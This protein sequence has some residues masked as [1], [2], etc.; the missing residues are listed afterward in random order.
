MKKIYLKQ[1]YFNIENIPKKYRENT[2]KLQINSNEIDSIKNEIKDM[3]LILDKKIELNGY[4]VTWYLNIIK[5]ILTILK[6]EFESEEKMFIHK[7]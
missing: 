3:K 5:E 1:N 6:N 4:L 7:K 2:L